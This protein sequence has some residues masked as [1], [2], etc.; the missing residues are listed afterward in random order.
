[1]E[2]D[3][4]VKRLATLARLRFTE[5][6]EIKYKA[7][8]LSIVDMIKSMPD[9]GGELQLLDS[10][11]PMELRADEVVPSMNRDKL[12]SGAPL[13]RAGCIVVPKTVE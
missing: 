5:E 4:D 12:L 13:V 9:I 3:I 8:M 11:N 1:M 10:K 2:I 6:E 7:E